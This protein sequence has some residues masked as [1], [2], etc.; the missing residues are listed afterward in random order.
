MKWWWLLLCTS[1]KKLII[2]DDYDQPL[3]WKFNISKNK[4]FLFPFFKGLFFVS[5]FFNTFFVFCFKPG[6]LTATAQHTTQREEHVIRKTHSLGWFLLKKR[7]KKIFFKKIFFV[8]F[9]FIETKW[10]GR[11]YKLCIE[12][13][14]YWPLYDWHV[15]WRIFQSRGT[16]CHKYGIWMIVPY[17]RFWSSYNLFLIFLPTQKIE[18]QGIW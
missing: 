10:K 2:D 15:C 9:L 13:R 18:C 8:A 11:R 1:L 7:K 5:Q 16:F 6:D 12:K 3:H 14:L 17:I 4:I